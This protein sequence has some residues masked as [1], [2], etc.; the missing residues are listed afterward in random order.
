MTL[1]EELPLHKI[2][3]SKLH[4]LQLVNCNILESTLTIMAELIPC[5][6]KLMIKHL[7]GIKGVLSIFFEELREFKVS[8]FLKFWK[9]FS[10]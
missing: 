7:R 4:V 8:F 5:L 2:T 3:L 9:K 1:F 10:N 6:E